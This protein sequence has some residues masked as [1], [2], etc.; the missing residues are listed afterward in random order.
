[1]KRYFSLLLPL[2]IACNSEK[3]VTSYNATPTATITSH[4]NA[5]EIQEGYDVS[6]QGLV[7]DANHSTSDLLVTWS[8]DL[9]EL[10]PAQA[11]QNDGQTLCRTTL[12][13]DESE[14]RLLVVDPE[15]ASSLTTVQ[16][17]VSPTEAPSVE[18]LSPQSDGAYYSD[19]SILFTALILVLLEK[20]ERLVLTWCI[21]Q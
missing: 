5:S 20:H 1:M 3:G 19:I 8:S 13:S 21:S 2:S 16:I 12:Q 18:I 4:T 7:T 10:C 9:R 14:I 11:P 15:A 6:M 17:E